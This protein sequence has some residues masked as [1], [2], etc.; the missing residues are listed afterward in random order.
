LWLNRF[1]RKKGL[2]VAAA[3]CG[4]REGSLGK[5][6]LYR[7]SSV[8]SGGVEV[9]KNVFDLSYDA[10]L[11]NSPAPG[12]QVTSTPNQRYRDAQKQQ[13]PGEGQASLRGCKP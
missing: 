10:P 4:H 3:C 7:L 2:A 12:P 11:N 1:G 9:S 5:S 13:G 6:K 8:Y